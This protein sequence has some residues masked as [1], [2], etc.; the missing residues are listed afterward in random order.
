MR[1]KKD[2]S[3]WFPFPDDPDKAEF[4]FKLL[5]PGEIAQVQDASLEI[6]FDF[7]DAELGKRL[8][9]TS[10]TKG[11]E[12]EFSFSC[13]GWKNVF[14]QLGA[15]LEF[16]EANKLRPLRE[17]PNFYEFFQDCQKKLVEIKKAQE[18]NSSSTSKGS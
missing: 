8:G 9:K 1:L 13:L 18:K 10:I 7:T 5:N 16:S 17:C 14:D 6:T 15:E 11:R 2:V 12:K 4:H 3:A